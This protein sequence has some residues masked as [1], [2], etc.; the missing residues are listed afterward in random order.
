MLALKGKSASLTDV[1]GIGKVIGRSLTVLCD[2]RVW[3][4]SENLDCSR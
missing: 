4:F 2:G 1:M 3:V